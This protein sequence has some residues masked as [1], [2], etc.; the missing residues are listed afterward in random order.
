MGVPFVNVN[1]GPFS[2]LIVHNP[3]QSFLRHMRFC[4]FPQLQAEHSRSRQARFAAG[5]FLVDKLAGTVLASLDVGNRLVHG[6]IETIQ[7]KAS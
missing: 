2:G 5:W 4:V 6:L 7:P 1:L 3:L